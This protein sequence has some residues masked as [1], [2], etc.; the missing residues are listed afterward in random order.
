MAVNHGETDAVV[1]GHG[2][3]LLTGERVADGLPVPAGEV[4][5]LKENPR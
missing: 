5:V 2:V 1:P 4:R 3:E